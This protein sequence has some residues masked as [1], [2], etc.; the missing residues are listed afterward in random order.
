M[1]ITRLNFTPRLASRLMTCPTRD[2]ELHLSIRQV[3][4]A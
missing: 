4:K 2:L 3:V 1:N